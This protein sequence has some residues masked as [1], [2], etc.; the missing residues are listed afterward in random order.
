MKVLKI[1][2]ADIYRDGGSYGFCFDS[3]DGHWYEFFLKT[4]AFEESEDS[5]YPPVIYYEGCNSN[6]IVRKFTW[7][8]AK[9][10]V[11]PLKYESIR[12]DELLIIVQNEGKRT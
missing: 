12:F 10:F 11:V 3:D 5:H 2:N 9:E 7:T 6:K 4:K 8:E 1:W